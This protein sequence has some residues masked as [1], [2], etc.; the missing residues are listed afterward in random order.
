[1]SRAAEDLDLEVKAAV[2]GVDDRIGEASADRQIRTRE[3]VLE[4][5]KRA[6]L[7]A[8]LLVIGDVQFDRAVERRAALFE[9][10]HRE[11]V[12]RNVRFRHC[13][14]APNHPAVDN[15]R[16]VRVVRP[17]GARRHH[18]AMGV[19]RDR[20]TTL[21]EPSPHDQVGRRNHAVGLDERL[22]NLVPLDLKTKSFQERGD[23]F[24]GA[25]AISGR[26]V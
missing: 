19:K 17:A 11:R 26:I 7:A 2:M 3:A 5:I 6:D 12:S 8:R 23:D 10:Q 14:S 25:A 9:R 15:L 4:Q 18:V 13:S 22:R 1:M 24:G 20:R 21:P 16:A